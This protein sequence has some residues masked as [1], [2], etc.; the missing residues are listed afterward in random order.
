MVS[1]IILLYLLVATY[2]LRTLTINLQYT[3]SVQYHKSQQ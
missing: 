3:L 2:Q 1:E